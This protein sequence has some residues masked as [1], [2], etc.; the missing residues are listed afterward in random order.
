MGHPRPAPRP[1][2]AASPFDRHTDTVSKPSAKHATS[3]PSPT[4]ALNPRPI[5]VRGELPIPR[6]PNYPVQVISLEYPPDERIF[7][8]HQPRYRELWIVRLNHR[9]KIIDGDRTVDADRQRLRLNRAEHGGAA[10]LPQVG[11]SLVSAARLAMVPVG[12]SRPASLPNIVATRVSS[13]LTVKSS[14][15]TSSPTSA[16]AIAAR[17]CGVGRVTVSERKSRR[18]ALDCM[19]GVN[20]RSTELRWQFISSRT[21][22]RSGRARSSCANPLLSSCS[23]GCLARSTSLRRCH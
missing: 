2:G 11:M 3:T 8:R 1:S 10:S 20:Y 16:A 15:N 22:L 18:I 14:P 9:V 19:I 17:I 7:D 13:A 4:A 5:K 21:R 12:S 23:P 6:K